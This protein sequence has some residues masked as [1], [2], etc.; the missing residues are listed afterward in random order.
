THDDG[1]GADLMYEIE[2]DYDTVNDYVHKYTERELDDSV[3][4]T[5][6]LFK[7]GRDGKMERVTDRAEIREVLGHDLESK[8]YTGRHRMCIRYV[9]GNVRH[10]ERMPQREVE[11]VAE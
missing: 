3:K 2:T 11:G 7:R 1:K 5:N 10:K 8:G 6:E 4:A 9:G